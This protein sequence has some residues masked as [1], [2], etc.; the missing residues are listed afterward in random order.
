[1]CAL[2]G[3]F[4]MR[5]R[6]SNLSEEG[7]VELGSTNP[8][9]SARNF[10]SSQGLISGYRRG[11]NKV[12]PLPDFTQRWLVVRYRRFGTSYL[13]HFM[14]QAAK[15]DHLELFDLW[16]GILRLF[17]NVGILPPISAALRSRGFSIFIGKWQTG[18][19]QWIRGSRSTIACKIFFFKIS[20]G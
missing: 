5:P 12:Y 15:E 8:R 19:N 14:A 18:S 1:M 4:Y 11:V 9:S 3:L 6:V 20:A 17:R 16:N 7:G 2:A 13:S 10:S